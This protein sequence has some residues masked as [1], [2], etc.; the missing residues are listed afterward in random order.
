[1][2]RTGKLIIQQKASC[3]PAVA[4]APPPGATVIDACAAPGNKTSHLAAIMGNRGRVFAFEVN[5]RR[6]EL[7][8]Q[9]MD[10]KGAR[11]AR[12]RLSLSCVPLPPRT[13]DLLGH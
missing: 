4:L 9:M 8:R 2:V 10:A 7:L 1:M 13:T 5:E 12:R 3:F 11:C 6:C